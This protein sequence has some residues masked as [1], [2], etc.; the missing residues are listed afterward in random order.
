MAVNKVTRKE[1]K[2][3]KYVN[4]GSDIITITEDKLKNILREHFSLIRKA[5]DWIGAAGLSVTLVGSVALNDFRDFIVS[6][7]VWFALYILLAVASFV[8]LAI[9]I[10]GA[11]KGKDSVERIIDDIK[12]KR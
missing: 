5:K 7:E 2:N 3:K 10:H 1:V 6:K 11:V 4:T 8:Y 12:N 9:C